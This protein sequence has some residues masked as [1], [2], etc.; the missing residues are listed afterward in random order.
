MGLADIA[1]AILQPLSNPVLLIYSFAIAFATWFYMHRRSK[2]VRVTKLTKE[3]IQ[4]SSLSFSLHCLS[5]F[6]AF[7]AYLSASNSF[8]LNF[9]FF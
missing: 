2:I 1:I 9:F 6:L 5:L 3:V 8:S 7:F 4:Y